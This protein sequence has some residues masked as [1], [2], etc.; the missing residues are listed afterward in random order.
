MKQLITMLILASGINAMAQVTPVTSKDI[1]A[2]VEP[3]IVVPVT[4]TSGN[5][6]TQN[7]YQPASRLIADG[8]EPAGLQGYIAWVDPSTSKKHLLKG[9]DNA[10]GE[11][12]FAYDNPTVRVEFNK[13]GAIDW[14]TLSGGNF[15]TPVDSLGREMP[16]SASNWTII[17]PAAFKYDIRFQFDLN[18][19]GRP[20]LLDDGQTIRYNPSTYKFYDIKISLP[21]LDDHSNVTVP[22]EDFPDRPIEQKRRTSK[23]ADLP[24]L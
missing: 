12:R 18:Y 20:V 4:Q 24:D 9:Q 22:L 1:K 17:A 13:N 16:K 7:S 2:K 8:K 19:T 21:F 3:K 5:T 11:W 23:F 10:S 15:Y 6:N 14:V